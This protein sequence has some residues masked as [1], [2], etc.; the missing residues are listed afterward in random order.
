MDLKRAICVMSCDK[1]HDH[2]KV[3]LKE[4]YTGGPVELAIFLHG[5]DPGKH[6]FHVHRNGNTECGANSLCDH[7]NPTGTVHGD[8]NDPNAHAGDLGNLTANQYGTV[9]T[10]IVAEYIRLR[11]PLSVIGRSLILHEDEDDLGRGGFSDSL[12]T[13]HSGKRILWGI[14]G[15]DDNP[16]M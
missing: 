15:I 7:F 4:I 12:I 9:Q 6:G 16:C 11:G 13:G 10:S 2:G 8:L 1:Y 3:I 14:I 5:I